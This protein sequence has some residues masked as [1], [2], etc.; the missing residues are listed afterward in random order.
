MQQAERLAAAWE[1]L[2]QT[3]KRKFIVMIVNRIAIL[4]DRIDISI[5]QTCF[6][7]WL[8]DPNSQF[9]LRGDAQSKTEDDVKTLIILTRLR[10]SGAEMKLI[11][12]DGSDPASPDA[13]LIR[14]LVRAHVIRHRL[15]H[16]GSL[17]LDEIAKSERIVPSYATRLFRLT[18]LAPDIVGAIL[19]GHQP[20][21]LTANRLMNDTRVPLDWGEQRRVLG[22]A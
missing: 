12:E 10:R 13:S 14:L 5:N 7:R 2:G 19:D 18:L 17:T 22:F 21:E 16:D 3:E 1:E 20:P 6:A 15:M 4:V 8:S 9:Q 11:V